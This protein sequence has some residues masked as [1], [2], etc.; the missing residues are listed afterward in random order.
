MC[1]NGEVGTAAVIVKELENAEYTGGQPRKGCSTSRA[2][3]EGRIAGRILI[4]PREETDVLAREECRLEPTEGT[5]PAAVP[6]NR[7]DGK[8]MARC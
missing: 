6:N 4:W 3:A 5:Q 1:Y 7:A 8:S 2:Q